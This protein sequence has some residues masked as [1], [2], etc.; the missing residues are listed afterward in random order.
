[1]ADPGFGPAAGDSDIQS[2]P[3][4]AASISKEAGQLTEGFGL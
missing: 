2:T 1:M 3:H 4:G